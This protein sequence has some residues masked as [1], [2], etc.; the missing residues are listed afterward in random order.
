MKNHSIA[1]LVVLA[2]LVAGCNQLRSRDTSVGASAD[3]STTTGKSTM[4]EGSRYQTS[5]NE[6][7]H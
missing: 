7:Q 5:S 4:P 1:T 3:Q 6:T 2:T